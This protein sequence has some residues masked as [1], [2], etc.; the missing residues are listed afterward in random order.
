MQIG[1]P[2][3]L[4]KTHPIYSESF[5]QEE[6]SSALVFHSLWDANCFSFDTLVVLA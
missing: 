4:Y 5:W 2:G 1:S 6:G 3:A